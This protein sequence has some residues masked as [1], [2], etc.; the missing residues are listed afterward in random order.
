MCQ[1]IFMTWSRG[2]MTPPFFFFLLLFNLV[3]LDC[4]LLSIVLRLFFLFLYYSSFFRA[5]YALGHFLSS[6]VLQRVGSLMEVYTRERL[7]LILLP[8]LRDRIVVFV[9]LYVHVD[10]H[11]VYTTIIDSTLV[12]L[13]GVSDNQSL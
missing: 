11:H 12:I 9:T 7:S 13:T 2:C 4:F 3:E 5:W 6:I 8:Q 10:P 1:Y